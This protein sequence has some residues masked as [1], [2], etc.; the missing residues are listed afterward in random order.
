MTVM[1][2]SVLEKHDTEIDLDWQEY[3]G[4]AKTCIEFLESRDAL[5]VAPGTSYISPE[6]STD[7]KVLRNQCKAVIIDR[8]WKMVFAEDEAEFD[9]LL[10]DM[11]DTANGLGYADVLA[12]DMRNAKDEIASRKQ[13]VEEYNKMPPQ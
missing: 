9:S 13:A 10:K 7:I 11:Q 3:A 5:A 6:E 4:G 12:V 1:W 8:S 2:S